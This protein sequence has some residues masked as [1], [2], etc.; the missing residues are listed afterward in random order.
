NNV[1][2]MINFWLS[3]GLGS[4]LENLERSFDAAFALPADEYV[5]FDERALLRMD[6]Q[7]RIT[8]ITKA[9]QGGVMSPNEARE[10]EDLPPVDGGDGVFLKQQMVSIDMLKELHPAT[11]AS[12]NKPAPAAAP[13][14]PAPADDTSE[15]SVDPE[16][17]KALVVELRHRKRR[18]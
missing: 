7:Q 11:T 12:K 18:A 17:A 3:T 4:L 13:G 1:E 5:E 6:Y 15:A 8:A 10:S 9:I 14:D 2:A 16:I